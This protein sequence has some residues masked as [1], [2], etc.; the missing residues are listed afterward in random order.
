MLGTA[1]AMPIGPAGTKVF[2]LEAGPSASDIVLNITVPNLDRNNTPAV[3]VGIA[4]GVGPQT[5]GATVTLSFEP[6]ARMVTLSVGTRS[7]TFPLLPGE[8]VL[9]VRAMTDTR[10]VEVFVGGGRGVYSGGLSYTGCAAIPC[11]VIA[12]TTSGGAD[13]VTISATAWAMTSIYK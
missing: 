11:T 5:C 6:S 4:C 8:T 9:P 7:M 12:G 3:K 1:T 13:T 10:S 2:G